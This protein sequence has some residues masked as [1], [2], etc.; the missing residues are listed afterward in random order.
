MPAKIKTGRG[1]TLLA[2]RFFHINDICFKEAAAGRCRFRV[3]I[4]AGGIPGLSRALPI[5]C[6]A[7][8]SVHRFYV[9]LSFEI[10]FIHKRFPFISEYHFKQQIRYKRN[11]LQIFVY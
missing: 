4:L 7:E 8:N 1:K 9:R 6:G 11:Q 10:F 2:A 5:L 3:E